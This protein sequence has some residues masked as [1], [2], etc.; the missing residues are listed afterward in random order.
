MQLPGSPLPDITLPSLYN[1]APTNPLVPLYVESDRTMRA[2][3]TCVH[4][5]LHG[6]LRRVAT[7]LTML[8]YEPAPNPR[9]R[10]PHMRELVSRAAERLTPRIHR[11]VEWAL[12]ATH[13]SPARPALPATG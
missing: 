10:S 6:L 12:T 9:V 1:D 4:R 8:E 7:L 5:S 2:I 3:S 13:T 11:H